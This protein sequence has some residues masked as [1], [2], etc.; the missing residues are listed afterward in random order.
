MSLNQEIMC[1][2]GV[3]T[4]YGQ[5]IVR[6][7]MPGHEDA[8]LLTDEALLHNIATEPGRWPF[9]PKT[10]NICLPTTDCEFIPTAD[11]KKA[12]ERRWKAGTFQVLVVSRHQGIVGI[13]I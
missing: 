11:P 10:K 5:P 9:D 2:L 6:R 4:E 3:V 8:G 7:E 13:R 12:P 1:L